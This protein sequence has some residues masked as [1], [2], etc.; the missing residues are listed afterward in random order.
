MLS[1]IRYNILKNLI[2]GKKMKIER[3]LYGADAD[4]NRGIDVVSVEL[5][6]SP[7]EREEIVEKIY[8]T[9]LDGRVSGTVEIEL[10]GY[11]VEVYIEDY[12]DELKESVLNDGD[13]PIE[14]IEFLA[15]ELDDDNLVEEFKLRNHIL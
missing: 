12:L 11:D 5:D 3:D 6:D 1:L 7:E 13:A 4:G 10:E 2:Q 9:F 14:S 15:E 8:E